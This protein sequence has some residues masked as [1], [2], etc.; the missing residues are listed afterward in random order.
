MLVQR[1]H[2]LLWWYI[3]SEIQ[4]SGNLFANFCEVIYSFSCDNLKVLTLGLTDHYSNILASETM[5]VGL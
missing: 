1:S 5:D 2:H 3:Y 4:K